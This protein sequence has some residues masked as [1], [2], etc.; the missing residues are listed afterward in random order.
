MSL[1]Q[2]T[3]IKIHL[4]YRSTTCMYHSCM[5]TAIKHNRGIINS[6]YYNASKIHCDY[7]V[8]QQNEIC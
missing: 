2:F 6:R 3:I 1:R 8:C 5:P 7:S 4:L